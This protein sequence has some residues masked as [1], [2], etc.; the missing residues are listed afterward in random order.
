MK[1]IIKGHSE[2][3]ILQT[4]S[5]IF[6][7]KES[8]IEVFNT[9]EEGFII[10]SIKNNNFILSNLYKNGDLIARHSEEIKDL[11]YSI[12][13][14][15]FLLLQSYT[16]YMPKWG[17]LTGIRP[18]K[19]IGSFFP[20]EYSYI[21]NIIMNDY[22]I[23][24]EKF[25]LAYK[26]AIAENNIL[27]K[28]APNLNSLYI[29]IPFCPSKCKYCTFTSCE[30]SK[31]QKKGI[32]DIYLEKLIEEI[33]WFGINFPSPYTIYIGGG[34]PTSLNENQ[35]YLLMESIYKYI[36]LKQT[37]EFTVECGRP[38]TITKEKLKIIKNVSR[39]SINTQT[40][41]NKTLKIIGRNHN[42]NDFCKSYELGNIMGF[43]NIN[44]DLIAGLPQET[45]KDFEK[46][47]EEITK[48]KP[49]SITIHSLSIK[50]G[51]H[52]S[53]ENTNYFEDIKT[54]DEMLK[55][56]SIYTK[57]INL[58]PYYM[59]RQK[60]TI[61]CNENVGYSRKNNHCIYNVEIM[62]DKQSIIGLGAGSTSKRVFLDTNKL[63][64]CFNFK[65]VEEYIK[66]FNEQIIRKEN[67][68]L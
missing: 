43:K 18:A 7:P 56:G 17:M 8:F 61:G 25:D 2:R 35:L 9:K 22:F 23:T 38:D 5:Q 46:T 37:V 67:L 44:I 33:K 63:E 19:F 42:Y 3:Y 50:R 30:V 53:L 59:Y 20:N 26:V 16:G 1:Y 62:E 48:L 21:K 47:M 4:T 54:I 32:V 41:H 51:S 55:I 36:D 57:K 49:H 64:R 65:N 11:K 10:E 14:S 29:G 6:Y 28:R 27:S 34:T 68:F 45:A 13:K 66:R 31:Y 58:E 39:I 60:N 12:K 15:L 24:E 52:L 40:V